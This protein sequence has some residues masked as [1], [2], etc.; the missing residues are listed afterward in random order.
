[1]EETTIQSLIFDLKKENN[2]EYQEIIRLLQIALKN[3]KKQITEA[4]EEGM[5]YGLKGMFPHCD[6]PANRYY[7]FTF[8]KGIIKENLK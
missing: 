6:Y 2:I 5:K 3:E 1:M 4:F 7:M 8:E